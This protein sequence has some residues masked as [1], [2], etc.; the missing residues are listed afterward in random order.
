MDDFTKACDDKDQLN[1]IVGVMLHFALADIKKKN[2]RCDVTETYRSQTR[3]NWIYC[4]GRSVSECVKAGIDE[5]FARK[6]CDVSIGQRTWTLNSKH[7]SR[8]AVD[9][10][11][12]IGGKLVWSHTAKEQISIQKSM[13]KYGFECG[14]NWKTNKDSCHY[15][16]DGAFTTVLHDGNC[17]KEL[18]KVIQHAL[19]KK[20][21]AGLVED[22]VWGKVVT[23][24]ISKF[25]S[26]M[27]YR[28]TDGSLG[29]KALSDL[30]E[31]L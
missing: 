1:V 30:F 12:Y 3:Q 10:V 27:G 29:A 26:A 19:N 2:I 20:I 7:K 18:T 31:I 24:A 13:A 4:K 11:P 23:S 14:A 6:Y 15:E 9:L 16:V 17:S 21:S 25:R 5:I 8:K 22:G 28:T